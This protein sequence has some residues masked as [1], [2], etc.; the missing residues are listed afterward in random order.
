MRRS[1]LLLLFAI[2]PP[3][4][5]DD[6]RLAGTLLDGE[7][8]AIIVAD[9]DHRRVGVGEVISDCRLVT[10]DRRRASFDCSGEKLALAIGGTLRKRSDVG[11]D[12]D[13]SAGVSVSIDRTAALALVRDRQQLVAELRLEPV[14]DEYMLAGYRLQAVAPGSLVDEAGFASGDILRSVNGVPA[15]GDEFTRML[16]NLEGARQV[17]IGFERDGAILE[18]LL[19]LN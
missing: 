9:G 1:F 19:I 3:V 5:A 7:G 2:A 18:S 17:L 10:V 12:P 8:A 15:G 14:V 16:N 13:R 6:W 4:A 11:N